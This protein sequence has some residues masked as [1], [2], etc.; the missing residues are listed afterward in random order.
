M[1]SDAAAGRPRVSPAAAVEVPRPRSDGEVSRAEIQDAAHRLLALVGKLPPELSGNGMVLDLV[2]DGTRCLVTRADRSNGHVNG[3]PPGPLPPG[4]LTPRE[5]EI[6]RM[7][8]D[9]FTNKE[10][11]SVLEI[12]S[13]T[14]STHLRRIF[15]KLDVGTRAAMVARLSPPFRS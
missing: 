8:A 10:I 15:G 5:Q 14:V 6:A 12:S 11:A 1:S 3:A 2:V 9:G 13:W 4:G 7:V